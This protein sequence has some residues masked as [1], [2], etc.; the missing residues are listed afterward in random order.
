MLLKSDV[1]A[2]SRTSCLVERA[3]YETAHMQVCP[4]LIKA[5]STARIALRELRAAGPARCDVVHAAAVRVR[6]AASSELCARKRAQLF[7]LLQ[8]LMRRHRGPGSVAMIVGIRAE[9]EFSTP[10]VGSGTG[11]SMSEE[12]R[13]VIGTACHDEPPRAICLTPPK[14]VS[15]GPRAMIH[16]PRNTRC[17]FLPF[18]APVYTFRPVSL[19]REAGKCACACFGAGEFNPPLLPLPP[20][21]GHCRV[22]AQTPTNLM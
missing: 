19:A 12:Y 9:R 10:A 5:P 2:A 14:G 1:V 11:V 13:D 7:V 22:G 3:N 15:E 17:G 6:V 8:C 18:P 21:K 16:L 20:R 4:P